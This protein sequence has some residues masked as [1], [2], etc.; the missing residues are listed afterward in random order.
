M[1]FSTEKTVAIKFEKRRK[2][3]ELHLTLQ[4]SPIQVREST[5]YLGLIIDKILNWKGHI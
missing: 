1:E 3:K 2:N 5:P 4:E